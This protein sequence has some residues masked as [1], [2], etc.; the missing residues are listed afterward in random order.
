MNFDT[1]I[2]G[3]GDF[4][5]IDLH[6]QINLP[7]FEDLNKRGSAKQK[8]QNLPF[9]DNRLSKKLKNLKGKADPQ[10]LS[11]NLSLKDIFIKQPTFNSGHAKEVE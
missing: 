6:K 4:N 11:S 8:L 2:L 1:D 10:H 3:S 5:L 9:Q 7:L